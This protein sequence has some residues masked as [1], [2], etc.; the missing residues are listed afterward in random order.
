MK[1]ERK[2]GVEE[3]FGSVWERSQTVPQR[4]IPICWQCYCL[5]SGMKTLKGMD[6]REWNDSE[7]E[8]TK[9]QWAWTEVNDP[10]TEN[11]FLHEGIPLVSK[12]INV[13]MF[14]F[15]SEMNSFTFYVQHWFLT[16]SVS[17]ALL[18]NCNSPTTPICW[19]KLRE[20]NT[21]Y[22]LSSKILSIC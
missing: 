14:F 12:W 7:R 17:V 13:I 16:R 22:L 5:W 11:K 20:H 3:W 15:G 4:E 1:K 6:W 10:F 19:H 8:I 9:G 2:N 18:N 21:G